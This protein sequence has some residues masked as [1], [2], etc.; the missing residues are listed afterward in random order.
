MSRPERLWSLLLVTELT[1]SWTPCCVWPCL[2]MGLDQTASRDLFQHQPCC[3][4]VRCQI[5]RIAPGPNCSIITAL[6]VK[7]SSRLSCAMSQSKYMASVFFPSSSWL[8]ILPVALVLS[9]L[10]TCFTH[11]LSIQSSP[12]TGSRTCLLCKALSCCHGS[13][14]Q[15]ASFPPKQASSS[16]PTAESTVSVCLK[17]SP[18]GGTPVAT[19]CSSDAYTQGSQSHANT[20]IL[21]DIPRVTTQSLVHRQHFWAAMQAW[22]QTYHG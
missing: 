2:N 18:F 13:H 21:V 7:T 1:Q 17:V 12:L 6:S 10:V 14:H 16:F 8:P 4:S 15:R 9:A 3:C 20:A 22:F 11:L 5:P 19:Y